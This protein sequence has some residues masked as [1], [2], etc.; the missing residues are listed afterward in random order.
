MN[1]ITITI[2][3]PEL[4]NAINALIV[5][6]NTN[7]AITLTSP[8]AS[9]AE[10]Q[11]A[12]HPVSAVPQPPAQ[13]PAQA[14]APVA[15]QPTYTIALLQQACAPLMDAGRQQDI[16]NLIHGFGVQA[17]TQIPKERLGDFATALRGLGAQI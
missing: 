7:K 12:V 8:D 17:L 5:S 1:N 10:P 15:A 9:A 2:E 16:V 14:Q 4:I 3:S 13:V 6:P 11:M